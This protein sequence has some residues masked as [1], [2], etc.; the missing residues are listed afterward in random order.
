MSERAPGV[1]GPAPADRRTLPD[2]R[3]LAD[4]TRERPGHPG[5]DRPA[6]GPAPGSPSSAGPSS[7][8]RSSRPSE[9]SATGDAA[10]APSSSGPTHEA[11]PSTSMSRHLTS[12]VSGTANRAPTAPRTQA[13]NSE[14]HEGD[15]ARQ[16]DGL[17]HHPGL[18]HRLDDRVEQRVDDDDRQH[19]PRPALEQPQD[20][21]RD[22]PDHEADVRDVVRDEGQQPPQQRVGDRREV[23]EHR[24]QDRDDEAEDRRHHEVEAGP[25]RERLQ[26]RDDGQA[27]VPFTGGAGLGGLP[28]PRF[29][30]RL[31]GRNRV[32]LP[33]SLVVIATASGS[34]AKWTSARG[35]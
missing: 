32:D 21:G 16:P 30:P 4:L 35:G 5:G 19:Q 18:D 23:Q 2:P 27:A 13:Q 10:G 20:R 14:R 15:G 1:P 22:H 28:L 6:D 29:S 26:S 8:P 3:R 31:N 17:T 9:S 34:T 7:A 25:A 12:R 11:R 24:V 33:A